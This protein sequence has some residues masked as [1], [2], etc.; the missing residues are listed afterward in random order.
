MIEQVIT[1]LNVFISNSLVVG[2]GPIVA[3]VLGAFFKAWLDKRT[4]SSIEK[5]RSE[6]RKR[7]TEESAFHKRSDDRISTLFN[8]SLQFR[9]ARSK[10]ISE[11]RI[12]A[13]IELWEYAV[14]AAPLHSAAKYSQ[15]INFKNAIPAAAKN[16][17]EAEKLKLVGDSL[18]KISG[19]DTYKYNS[20][21]DKSQPLIPPIVW[22]TFS[23]YRSIAAYPAMLIL[24]VKTGMGGKSLASP[25]DLVELGKS[26]LPQY[27]DLFD[28]KG[29]EF[30][31]F[32]VDELKDKLLS[33]IV[34][35][36]DDDSDDNRELD[37]AKNILTLL[38]KLES[39]N[40]VEIK[41]KV[42]EIPAAIRR[43]D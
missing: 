23:A 40:S 13:L 19:L 39:L 33:E 11:K 37:R 8:Q 34:M 43:S 7:E 38:S 27:A 21:A 14:N 26:T 41:L 6:L 17:Q 29:E 35:S 22:A 10:I 42:D 31:P 1:Y 30:L 3:F 25:K 24:E 9:S 20:S 32:V 28:K 4:T 15:L 5:L 2:L 36:L 16:D 18:W 12:V